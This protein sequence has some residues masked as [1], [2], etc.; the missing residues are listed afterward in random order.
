MEDVKSFFDKIA[1][2]Y[3]RIVRMAGADYVLWSR[4]L[5]LLLLQNAPGRKVL[6]IS[7]GTGSLDVNL[8]REG[9]DVYAM[10]VS[11]PML[12][13]AVAR[14]M[15]GRVVAGSFFSIP[16]SGKS[17]DAAISTFDSLNTVLSSE[18]LL[19]VFRQ[20]YDVLVDGGVFLFD[21]NSPHSYRVYWDGLE[22]VDEGEGLVVIWRARREGAI[23]RL[24][25]DVFYREGGVWKRISGELRE[26]AYTLR[27]INGLLHRAGFSRVVCLNHMGLALCNRNTMRYQIIAF[28]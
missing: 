13:Q 23:T 15:G 20:V 21:M 12:K 28:K 11:F 3:D 26:R 22:R 27:V 4:Y 1:P 5:K 24:A 16:F 17:F 9:F 7:A 6:D 14:G 8:L 19:E 25:I 10:D 18:G 2:F